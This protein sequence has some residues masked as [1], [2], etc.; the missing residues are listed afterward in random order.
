[1]K[2]SRTFEDALRDILEAASKAQE[3]L[4]DID[5]DAFAE[6]EDLPDLIVAVESLVNR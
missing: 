6:D 4:K 3:F 2:G 5:Q 1:M